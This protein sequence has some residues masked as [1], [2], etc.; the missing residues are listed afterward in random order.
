VLVASKAVDKLNW[1]LV[2][3]HRSTIII[4]VTELTATKHVFVAHALTERL[5][6]EGRAT[7]IRVLN[8]IVNQVVAQMLGVSGNGNHEIFNVAEE[9]ADG[10][11]QRNT[12]TRAIGWSSMN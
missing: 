6:L 9:V 5:V 12:A 2:G 4:R 1:I 10:L 3:L 8:E 11:Q 7:D